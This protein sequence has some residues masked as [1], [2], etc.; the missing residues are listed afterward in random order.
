MVEYINRAVRSFMSSGVIDKDKN[1]LISIPGI[2]GI[3]VSERFR[4]RL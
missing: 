1:N 2:N 3:K 4:A